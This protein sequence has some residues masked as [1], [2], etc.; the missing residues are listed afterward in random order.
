MTI[1]PSAV[2]RPRAAGRLGRALAALLVLSAAGCASG[3]GGTAGG[4]AGG[5]TPTTSG[6][7]AQSAWPVKT[8]EHVDLWLHAYAM[9]QE[10][11]TRIPYF[12]RGYRDR[13]IV[14]RNQANATSKLDEH[15]ERLRGRLASSPG[16][17]NGQFLA[18]YF[19]SWDEMR[20]AITLFLRAEGD[21]RRASNQQVQQAIALLA[22]YFPLPADREW[23]NYFADGVNDESAKFYHAYWV[24]EQQTRRPVLEAADAAW[25]LGMLPKLRGFI[26]NTQQEAGELILSLPLDGEGRTINFGSRQN[27]LAVGFPDDRAS[28]EEAVYV[29]VHELVGNVTNVAVRDNV[30]PTEA[31]MGAVERYGGHA[32]VRGGALLLA[33]V[34]PQMLDGYARYYLRAANVSPAGDP[35]AQLAATFPLPPAIVDAITRQIDVV[36][37]G[38]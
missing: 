8:R 25:R 37:G 3:G 1:V 16:L 31:R 17:V 15:R 14:R 24:Q 2:A 4:T 28:A 38:I 32:L 11:T 23:L 34:A 6:D 5:T 26:N 30:T 9:L 19:G 22:G 7:T 36:L 18:L 35:Q 21:P 29:A 12:E 13:M 33:K 10:D 27:V 20:E